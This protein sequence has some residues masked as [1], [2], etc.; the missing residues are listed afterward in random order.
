M[1]DKEYVAAGNAHGHVLVSDA[2]TLELAGNG[3][4]NA[5]GS[6]LATWEDAESKTRWLLGTRG[7]TV[8]AYKVG[9]A[10]GRARLAVGLDVEGDGFACASD[11][12]ERRGVR[13]VVGCR[14]R[15]R[16]CCMR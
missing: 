13:A 4:G 15:L 12:G 10:D 16:R 9:E 14:G 7:G 6:A 2:G 11:C 1:K 8:V 5:L 3:P